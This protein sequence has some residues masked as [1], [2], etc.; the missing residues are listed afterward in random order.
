M[1]PGKWAAPCSAPRGVSKGSSVPDTS[2]SSHVVGSNASGS[3]DNR[4]I[5]GKGQW[6]LSVPR[7]PQPG[8]TGHQ[9]AC[10][11][12]HGAAR[13]WSVQKVPMITGQCRSPQSL[14]LN[15]P[16]WRPGVFWLCGAFPPHS[17]VTFLQICH[18]PCGQCS[19]ASQHGYSS[20]RRFEYLKCRRG[21][22]LVAANPA[23][24][25][26]SRLKGHGVGSDPGTATWVRVHMLPPLSPFFWNGS[27]WSVS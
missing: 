14:K 25:K 10:H 9:A 6:L 4:P 1:S 7:H 19:R 13:A 2:P 20:A 21:V 8:G 24:I 16:L 18:Q 12:P 3:P 27:E 5:L 22:G 15:L 23:A 11:H 26:G 17:P